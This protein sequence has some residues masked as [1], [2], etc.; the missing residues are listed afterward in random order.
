MGVIQPIT[1]CCSLDA[2][3]DPENL[4]HAILAQL[5]QVESGALP[6]LVGPE[7]ICATLDTKR[8]IAP[9]DPFSRKQALL[10]G[11]V[12]AS[13]LGALV[14]PGT[15]VETT[16]EGLVNFSSVYY[17]G[18]RITRIFKLKQGTPAEPKQW[19]KQ[20]VL[21]KDGTEHP[22]TFTLEYGKSSETRFGIEICTDKGE[23]RKFLTAKESKPS[24]WP[25]VYVQPSYGM[26]LSNYVSWNPKQEAF[27]YKR[28]VKSK[29]E[30]ETKKY[31]V[32]AES[33][34]TAAEFADFALHHT[35]PGVFIQADGPFCRVG[36]KH[37]M[38]ETYT[39]VPPL[40]SV[41][42]KGWKP[43]HEGCSLSVHR[44]PAV[45][46]NPLQPYWI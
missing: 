19:A 31:T 11:L 18:E 39:L 26:S 1:F 45:D 16:N 13:G 37:P 9:L 42:V 34:R 25:D 21:G 8:M 15:Q 44:F 40:E 23:M 43:I 24:R 33:D 14:I 7:F 10:V 6:V 20:L 29:L 3:W 30:W 32:D 36:Y 27:Q 4:G 35:A 17:G 5:E 46:I 2:A 41:P 28:V 12:R 22:E 38:S